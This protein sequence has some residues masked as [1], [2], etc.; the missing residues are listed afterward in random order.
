MEEELIVPK[1]EPVHFM[2]F[3]W[4]QVQSQG[5]KNNLS[6]SP[7]FWKTDLGQQKIIRA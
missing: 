2:I 5:I 7:F 6:K 1:I 3:S 4:K